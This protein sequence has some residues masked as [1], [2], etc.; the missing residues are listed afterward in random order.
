MTLRAALLCVGLGV[1]SASSVHAQAPARAEGGGAW[2]TAGLGGGWVR[3]NCAICR[4]D[5][6]AGPS[7]A[8]SFGT[9]LRPGLLVGGELDGW[10]RSSDDVR[11]MLTAGGAAAWIYPDPN[12]R[13]Y[14]KAGAGLVHYS[15][16]AD[17]STNLFGL[18]LGAGYE[19]PISETMSI[20]NSIGITASSFG[21]LRSEDGTVADDVS[22]SLFQVGIALR[23]R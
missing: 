12:R 4:T 21:A 13:L 2:F 23:H 3:V 19:F 17:V 15:L 14:L 9:T 8:V 22:I 11:S 6:N 7:A 20:A 10:T 18:M 16:D 1:W 5:R